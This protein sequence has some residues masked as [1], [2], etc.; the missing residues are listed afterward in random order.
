MQSSESPPERECMLGV[1]T[2]AGPHERLLGALVEL[3][4][5]ASGARLPL[6]V[7]RADEA[8]KE[9]KRLVDQLDDY[10]IPRLRQL[11][12]PLL[13][14]VGGS[15]GAGKSTLINSLVGAAVSAPGVLR[16]TTRAPVLVCNPQEQEWF[17]SQRILPGLSRTTGA[18]SGT[19]EPPHM[20]LHV[21]PVA[22][23]P[24]GLALLDA[25]DIDSVVTENRELAI[26]LLA[27]ADLWIFVTTAARYADAVPWDFLAAAQE[28]S[29]A[30]A[31]VLDR[32]PPEATDEVTA[33]L[34]RMLA[35][36]GLGEA[37]LFVVPE[38]PLDA[39]RLLP[40][41]AI[42]P[43]RIWLEGLADDAEQRSRVARRTLD[44][45]LD[46]FSDRIM[47]LADAADTQLDASARLRAQVDAA[48]S[49]AVRQV[50]DGLSDG[51]LLRGEVLARWQEFV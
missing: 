4:D 39:D 43:V 26:Q 21:V 15:T 18:A 28:R 34:A 50:G 45:A 8:R 7:A 51:T 27:A 11:D 12:A 38:C 9:L 31:V 47:G 5:R 23:L 1:V 14:V 13:A 25:P 37:P 20:T 30:I 49:H 48:Y 24:A 19:T 22:S 42:E 16:P 41:P 29:A 32:V 2:S 17:T 35:S 44:G 3:R 46:S 40:P 6:Q 10:V 36:H 33:H